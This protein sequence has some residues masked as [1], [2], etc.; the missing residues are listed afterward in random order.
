[1]SE[2][3]MIYSPYQMNYLGRGLPGKVF[4]DKNYGVVWNIQ[5]Y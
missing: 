3:R 5:Y 4:R 2:D 1:M